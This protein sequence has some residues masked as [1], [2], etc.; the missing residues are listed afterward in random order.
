MLAV[1]TVDLLSLAV[2]G[3]VGF[4]LATGLRFSLRGSGRRLVRE[5]VGGLGWRHLWPVPF[6]LTAVVVVTPIMTYL[7]LP[8]VT[9]ALRPWLNRPRRVR[10]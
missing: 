2:L 3:L 5:I 4:R 8:L 1:T 6:V 7:A 9:R 10:A